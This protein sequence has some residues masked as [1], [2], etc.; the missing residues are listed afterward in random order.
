M[1]DRTVSDD[2]AASSACCT[3]GA[4][5]IC[6]YSRV[7]SQA[8]PIQ[9]PAAPSASAAATWRPQPIPP[10]ASTGTRVADRV[11]DLRDEHHAPDLAGVAAGLVPLGDDDVHAAGDLR[12]GVLRLPGQRRHQHAALVRGWR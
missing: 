10:A 3:A 9:T 1:R 7:S 6:A 5:V 4:V 12:A 11:D 2:V 8:E